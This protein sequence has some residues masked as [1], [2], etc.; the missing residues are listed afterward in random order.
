MNQVK[1]VVFVPKTHTDIV[2]KAMGDAGAGKIGNYSY[3]SYSVDGVGRYKPQE[4]AQPFIGE[5]GKFEEVKEER[6]ECVCEKDK[7]KEV[8][9]AIKKV[10][11]YEE[12][13]LDIYPL[14]SEGEL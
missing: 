6:I 1:I 3:C 10:Y 4:G 2:R 7:A 5:V 14:I 13:A 11:P 9:A 8:I 12:V